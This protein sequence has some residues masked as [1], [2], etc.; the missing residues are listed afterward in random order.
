MN[1]FINENWRLI[2]KE[3]GQLLYDAMGNVLNAI[4]SEAAK[5]VPYDD[6]FDDVE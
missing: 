6:I 1:N 5:T 2:M 4:F 3:A